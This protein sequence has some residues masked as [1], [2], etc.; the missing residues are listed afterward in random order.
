[1]EVRGLYPGDLFEGDTGSI[2]RTV[3]YGPRCVF[4]AFLY[5]YLPTTKVGDMLGRI[6]TPLGVLLGRCVLH[7]MSSCVGALMLFS[8][9]VLLSLAPSIWGLQQQPMLHP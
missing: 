2:I 5:V 1:M 7:Q 6:E 3:L 4:G 8:F 9:M